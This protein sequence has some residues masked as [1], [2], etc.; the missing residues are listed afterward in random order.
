M[1][2]IIKGGVAEKFAYAYGKAIKSGKTELHDYYNNP[3][4]RKV[5][6]NNRIREHANSRGYTGYAVIGGNSFNFTVAYRNY[7]ELVVETKENTYHIPISTY[8]ILHYVQGDF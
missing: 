5:N 4:E 1:E 7:D 3:S 2:R 8:T 6:I